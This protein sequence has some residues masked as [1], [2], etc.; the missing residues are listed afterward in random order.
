MEHELVVVFFAHL[1]DSVRGDILG[2]NMLNIV[3]NISVITM[4]SF[5]TGMSLQV[6]FSARSDICNI[7]QITCTLCTG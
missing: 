1:V 3:K 6:I 2:E 4:L 5:K 7:D